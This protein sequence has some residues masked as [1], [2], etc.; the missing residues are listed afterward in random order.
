MYFINTVV[1]DAIFSEGS[2]YS[3]I[4]VFEVH[5]RNTDKARADKVLTWRIYDDDDEFYYRGRTE[6]Y[7]L[8]GEDFGPTDEL[9]MSPL[10]D[11][12]LGAGAVEIRWQGHPDWTCR[13]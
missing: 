9:L 5:G 6:I 10:E 4:G 8:Q 1:S 12:G 3:L 13:Y 2:E 7:D 11:F